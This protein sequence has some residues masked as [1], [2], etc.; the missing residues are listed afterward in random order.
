[1]LIGI[2]KHN[3]WSHT[4]RFQYTKYNKIQHNTT[5]YNTIQNTNQCTSRSVTHPWMKKLEYHHSDFRLFCDQFF[6][7]P[8]SGSV[9]SINDPTYFQS[10]SDFFYIRGG[11]VKFCGLYSVSF[12]ILRILHFSCP[13]KVSFLDPGKNLRGLPFYILQHPNLLIYSTQTVYKAV[14]EIRNTWN[15]L[16]LN[17]NTNIIQTLNTNN[18]THNANVQRAG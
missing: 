2:T 6:K 10:V 14:A 18:T 4:E 15:T 1:M 17:S 7:Y 3:H 16:A 11:N 9:R 12:F 5:K 8:M 13:T